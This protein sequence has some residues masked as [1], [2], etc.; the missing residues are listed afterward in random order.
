MKSFNLVIALLAL[1]ACMPQY[2]VPPTMRFRGSA[3]FV[4]ADLADY[5]QACKRQGGV[6]RVERSYSDVW[7]AEC[8]GIE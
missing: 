6:P 7:D 4:W 3:M 1:S 8:K 2:E 5:A